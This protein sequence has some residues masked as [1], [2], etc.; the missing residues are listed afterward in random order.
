MQE[1][2]NFLRDAFFAIIE[3]VL[4][5]LKKVFDWILDFFLEAVNSLLEP[6]VDSVPDLSQFWGDNFSAFLYHANNWVDLGLLA[7]LA[8]AYFIFILG[9]I[10]VKLVLKLFVPFVG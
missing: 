5:A 4:E 9:M 8:T 6:V 10:I 1:I 2:L 3:Y 7:T